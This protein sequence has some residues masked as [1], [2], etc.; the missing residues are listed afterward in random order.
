MFTGI[1]ECM[2]TVIEF[3]KFDTSSA[4]GNGASLSISGAREILTDC[5]LGDSIAINGTC[6]TVTEFTD[7]TFKVGLAPETLS[8]T[9]LGSLSPGDMVNLERAL[10]AGHRFGGHFVQGHVD[11]TARIIE[12]TPDEN[13]VWFKLRVDD[14]SIMRYIIPKGF[15]AIDGTSL[16][17]CDV[18]DAEYWFTIMMVAYTQ[19]HVVLPRKKVGDAVNVEV[20][21]LGKYVEKVT[22]SIL[23]SDG[24]GNGSA[25]SSYIENIVK[26]VLDKESSTN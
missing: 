16:T 3:T 5:H 18:N 2:G 25:Q 23:C 17:V 12:I 14:K 22:T 15:I 1:V 21:M 8:R 11:T 19:S 10:A 9:N 26:R 6:L 13:S 24:N 7:D 4:G 20:D